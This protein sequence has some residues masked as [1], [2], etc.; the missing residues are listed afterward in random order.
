MQTVTIMCKYVAR[1]TTSY[2]LVFVSVV[3]KCTYVVSFLHQKVRYVP[4]I[5]TLLLLIVFSQKLFLMLTILIVLDLSIK[6][7]VFYGST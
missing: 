7:R 6:S 3:T 4:V 5:C 2:I 1:E